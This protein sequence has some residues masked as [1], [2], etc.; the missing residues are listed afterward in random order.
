MMGEQGFNNNSDNY[1][2]GFDPIR[3]YLDGERRAMGWD[4]KTIAA[5]FGFHPRMADH[6]FSVSQWS[7]IRPEQ[8]ARLQAE[9]KG[10]GFKRDHDELK[11]EFYA[12]RAFFDN[13]HDNMTDV[14][15]FPRVQ[16]E[17][18]HGHATPKPVEMVARAIKSSAPD[19]AV[20]IAPF[21]GTGPEFVAAEQ[22]KR[23]CYGI[24]LEPKYCAVI[25]ERMEEMGLKPEREDG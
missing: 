24:E 13:T 5:W 16:G 11:R 15:E 3:K 19:G 10:K 1:W 14:W 6:W 21:G 7:F 2:E 4:M 12:T 8:Y 9:A 22:L 25:L 23:K 18:R 20:V 17:E